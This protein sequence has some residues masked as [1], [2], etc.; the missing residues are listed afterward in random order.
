[1][2]GK[3]Y[4]AAFFIG[5]ALL[6]ACAGT[7]DKDYVDK[8]IMPAGTDSSNLQTVAPGALPANPN[9]LPGSAAM[10]PGTGT[11]INL[12]QTTP[13]TI[14]LN[15]AGAVP[16]TPPGMNP[17]HGQPGHRCD[18]ADGAPLNSKPAPAAAPTA[19]TAQPA[20]SNVTMTEVPTPTK[21]APGMNPAHGQPGH[22]CDIAV[23]EPLNSKPPPPSVVS[24]TPPPATAPAATTAITATPPAVTKV[25]PGMN[26][27]HGE[28]GH[29]C[30]IE[31]GKPLNSKPA[32]TKDAATPPPL[33]A[34]VKSGGK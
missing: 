32:P 33:L 29:R 21:T 12:G 11:P 3:I 28:P 25:A 16:V 19:I 18:I 23:G 34:P 6:T 22:R 15:Q 17:P 26:P 14:S 10:N 8:S 2:I 9:A 27:A 7:S 1:M 20:A 24:T 30:D 4:S 5:I 31:V 13:Q